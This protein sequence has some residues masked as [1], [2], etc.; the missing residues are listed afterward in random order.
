MRT[1][2]RFV[3]VVL[4]LCA[5]FGLVLTNTYLNPGTATIMIA[6]TFA[7]GLYAGLMLL[8]SRACR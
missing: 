3:A 8:L 7:F 5:W 1:I 4:I 6:L 2:N